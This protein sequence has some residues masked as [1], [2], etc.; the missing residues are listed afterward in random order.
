M[1]ILRKGTAVLLSILMVL[2]NT[3]MAFAEELDLTTSD[4]NV[5]E[6]ETTSVTNRTISLDAG[7]GTCNPVSITLEDGNTLPKLPEPTRTGW[8]FVGWYTDKVTENFWGDEDGETFSALK[9]K[10]ES[11][12][13][14]E[15]AQKMAQ[16]NDF[17][18][19][20]ESNGILAK[21]GGE[22]PT[23]ISTL[24]AMYEPTNN[25][26]VTWYYNGWKKN[27]GKFLTHKE[28]EYDS[29]LVRAEL[30]S[31]LPWEGHQFIG[32]YTKEGEEW[33]FDNKIID[34][35]RVY[36]ISDQVVT[37]N[38]DLYARWTG[39]TE[40]DSI[41]LNYKNQLVEPGEEFSVT[42]SYF[43]LS[44]DAPELEWSV[45]DAPDVKV[46]HQVSDD[47]F[48]ITLS[49][50]QDAN[51]VKS[52][53]YVTVTAK[54][55]TNP[56]LTA[57]VS[58]TVG[59]SWKMTGY[60]D[61]TCDQA[62]VKHYQCTKHPNAKKDVA[63]N[64]DGHRFVKSNRIT[65]EP[66]CVAEGSY[67]D[68]YTCYV[69]NA[70]NQVVTTIPATGIHTWNDGDITTSPT[71]AD[72]GIKTYTC[73]ECRD[74]M[75]EEIPA[76]G[77]HIWDNGEVTTDPTCAETGIMT[78]TCLE[79]ADTYESIIPA[80]EQH[81]YEKTSTVVDRVPD[82]GN[83]GLHTDIY[84]CTVC[85]AGKT[86]QIAD[87]ATGEH[88]FY[89]FVTLN[90]GQRNHYRGCKVCGMTEFL[91]AEQAELGDCVIVLE[92]EDCD[93]NGEA[94]EP[95][96]TVTDGSTELVIGQDY[97]V[98]Y[99][100]NVNVG[101]AT[102][103]ITGKGNYSGKET[104]Y[105]SIAAKDIGD[106]DVSVEDIFAAPTGKVQTPAPTVLWQNKK[107][108]NNKDFEVSYPDLESSSLTDAYK[109]AGIYRVK[110]KGI[111]NFT[112]ERVINFHITTSTLMSKVKVK[113]IPKQTYTRSAIE[114]ALTVTYG[115]ATLNLGTDYTVNY[116]NNTETGKA[117]AV[118]TGMGDY[119]GTKEVTFQIVGTSIAKATVN[120]LTDKV[121]NGQ[122]QT[123]DIEVQ[124]DRKT[125]APNKD[126]QIS[127]TKNQNVGTATV[128][129][130]GIG[131]YS[132]TVKKAFKITAYDLSADESHLMGG[133]PENGL[134]VSYTKGGS[135]PE[136]NL[137]FDGT[138]LTA[139]KDYTV[140][141]SNNKKIAGST[142]AKKPTITIKGKGNF[143]GTKTISFNITKRNLT[144]EPVNILV[145]DMPYVNKA[146]KYISKP[147]LT[148]SNGKRLAAGT[149]YEKTIIYT[150]VSDG[151]SGNAA[152]DAARTTNDAAQSGT[153][154]NK[155]SIPAIG[156]LI[157]VTI[158]GKG[159]YEGTMEAT[160]RIASSSFSSAKITI[161]P[162][163]YTGSA[164]TLTEKDITV[165]LGKDTVLTYGKDYEI[166]EGSYKNNVKK[167]TASVM[168]R[169]MDNY[170]G[171]KTVKFKIATS[172]SK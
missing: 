27:T 101:T 125:L 135:T 90:L 79:C 85:G 100:D 13:G 141:Y 38:L 83:D 171:T 80:T 94:V 86:E 148:D 72:S 36:Y 120:G 102:V 3:S 110:I 19:I 39:R 153:V 123:Q 7:A 131:S 109:A 76:T 157:K 34:G 97:T 133:F 18:W 166:V 81:Q 11:K 147:V 161:A 95:T 111:N 53:K 2:S 130:T 167:G 155:T 126:Y 51:A 78:F 114:P 46:S 88:D 138:E 20:V 45:E 91:Y 158:T 62:G 127:Y 12:Y 151:T 105:F 58:I 50:D 31:L 65:K 66:T 93:Y 150:L 44:A 124:L 9:A 137:S 55:K 82:C 103:Q 104:V 42:A 168:I 73:L 1:R 29:P 152:D 115:K 35:E 33:K 129:I 26:T 69:C 57:Q 172:S 61:S 59:H 77:L 136:V 30:E 162:Q 132:G 160:Y 52:N 116:E 41:S 159:S 25:I 21:E 14:E 99:S 37:E 32:W 87:P 17:T 10:Y 96:V 5:I 84:A 144:E 118:L 28:K 6:I 107:L 117:T 49:I 113:A 63:I 145:S 122:E 146:G 24:Y 112:G 149:D 74:T 139:K 106:T 68:I 165:K 170:A 64:P 22:L 54:S 164:V 67:T 16:D 134:N 156:S 92:E 48:K 23:N 98:S 128:I 75:E 70:T 121:Y 43:P 47:G 56:A 140:S 40:P 119:A 60:K 4:T 15:I 108:L 163:S 143:K 154:L 8:T 142:D 89:E 169:G 71:C